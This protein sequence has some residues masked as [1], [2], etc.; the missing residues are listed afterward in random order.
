[1][2]R[3]LVCLLISVHSRQISIDDYGAVPHS[4]SNATW[5]GQALYAA[6][7]DLKP[8]DSLL[9]PDTTY[10]VLPAGAVS[11]LC[12]NS[13]D[14]TGTL[15][16][17]PDPDAWIKTERRYIPLL[18]IQNSTGVYIGG[19]GSIKGKGHMWWN[20]FA[21]GQLKVKRP[22]LVEMANCV[23]VTIESVHLYDSPRFHLYLENL[24]N[25]VIK[26]IEIKVKWDKT[27][28]PFNTD[29][30]DVS[31]R[32]IYIGNSY[33]ENYDDLVAIKPLSGSR[34]TENVLVENIR[35]KHG[36]G[37]SIGAVHPTDDH[38][39]VRNVTFRDSILESPLKGI[40]VKSDRGKTEACRGS[41]QQVL[42]KNISIGLPGF[43]LGTGSE[44]GSGF[45]PYGYTPLSM[46]WPIYIGPQQQIEPNGVG[47]GLWPKTEPNVEFGSIV[48]EDIRISGHWLNQPG[49]I[50]CNSTNPC[51][52][53]TN[54]S[55][56]N[57]DKSQATFARGSDYVC[58]Y[59]SGPG[60][61]C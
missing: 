56:I 2:Y 38:T 14:L 16:A 57:V 8:N 49:V 13:I 9:I 43:G 39:C 41:I 29:G 30:I 42:Y 34:C 52:S 35:S 60:L 26:D 17:L 37:L 32:D 50:R 61:S 23:N 18:T 48:L 36:V 15:I 22:V 33:I 58:E 47:S 24:E 40:Y 6:L 5:N 46:I 3:L 53:G 1:M 21:L 27:I 4:K 44:S 55:F 28:F 51:T 31:G 20:A 11:N 10:W 45:Q 54:V 59:A 19:G 12:N 7:S 25:L